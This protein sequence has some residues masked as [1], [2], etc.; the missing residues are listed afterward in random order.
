MINTH[1]GLSRLERLAQIKTLLGPQ[2]LGHPHCQGLRIFA[3][4]LNASPKSKVCALIAEHL[5]DV[6]AGLLHKPKNTFSGRLP[7]FR[8]DHIFVDPDLQVLDVEVPRTE[9]EKVSSDH[10]PLVAKLKLKR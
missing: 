10:L 8:I 1:L 9:L 2:W 5:N 6:Q 7:H 3:G 4:D